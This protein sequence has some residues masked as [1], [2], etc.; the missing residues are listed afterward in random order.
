M[1]S[2]NSLKNY[3]FALNRIIKSRRQL[4][5]TAKSNTQF[6]KSQQAF[7][8]AIKEFKKQ[9]K[10]KQKVKHEITEADVLF[11]YIFEFPGADWDTGSRQLFSNLQFR[12]LGDH[13]LTKTTQLVSTVK[14]K[15]SIKK[16]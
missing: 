4:D 8:N 11:V 12:N 1:Y 7:A 10:V 2:A 3:R 16:N 15:S 5:I 9:G 13:I 14:N 6:S